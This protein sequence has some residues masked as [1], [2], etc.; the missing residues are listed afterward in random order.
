MSMGRSIGGEAARTATPQAVRYDAALLGRLWRYLRP[1]SGLAGAS[2]ALLMFH[3]A[4]AVVLPLLTQVAVDRYLQPVRS[5]DSALDSLL[6]QEPLDGLMAIVGI[7]LFVLGAS[8]ATRSAQIHTMN[9]TGQRVMRDMRRDIFR[10]LQ[11]L[12]VPYFDRTP[13]GRLVTRVTTDV[14]VL[15]ELFTSGL[16]AVAGDVLTLVCAFAAMLYLSPSLALVYLCVGPLVLA[17][18][19]VFRRY[20]RSSFRDVRRAVAKLA[21]FLQECFSGI[22]EVQLFGHEKQALRDFEAINRE[23]LEA[24]YRAVRAHALFFPLIDWLNYLG[25]ALLVAIGGRWVVE[26]AMTLGV[27]LAFLQYGSRVFRPIQDLAE[28][29]NVLQSAMAAAER[30]FELLDTP[31]IPRPAADLRTPQRRGP[32]LEFRSVW[33]AYKGEDWVLRDVSF[34]VPLRHTLAVVGHTGAG[35][36]TLVNLLLRFYEIQRG[37]I[38][39]YGQDIREWR[40]EELRRQFSVVLQD[41]C[42]FSGTIAD[43]IGLG[44]PALSGDQIR[45]AASRAHLAEHVES[46]RD[47]YDQQVLERGAGLSV[48]QKQLV[49]FARAL[50]RDRPLLVL[51]EATSSV[52]PDTERAI[53]TTV[54][55]L[56]GGRTA[57]VIAHRLSTVRQADRIVVLH[58]GRVRETGNH[59]ALL[60]AGG[61]YARLHRLQGLAD[62]LGER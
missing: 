20:A 6:P 62:P 52:D 3:S 44:D 31:G 57:M 48:G 19:V 58:R 51:D 29:Y 40:R 28:K 39:V 56:L 60:E 35:K 27:L 16:V 7:Y 21:S 13:S 33:F 8:A 37:S 18:S 9:V 12:P 49:G 42:L 2:L 32:G 46:L 24:N 41:P 1:Y 25:L 59:A 26:G 11:R 4:L 5:G 54:S 15:N 14:D 30:I 47:G 23:H 61:L 45:A 17:V 43:N 50:A 10:H 34:S 22:S 36:T 55:R 53:R 38:L